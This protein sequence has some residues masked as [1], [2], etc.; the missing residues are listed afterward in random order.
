MQRQPRTET[1]E[2]VQGQSK[3]AVSVQV[4]RKPKRPEFQLADSP[5]VLGN[6]ERPRKP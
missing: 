4:V 3:R 5:R 1:I 2:V 6:A